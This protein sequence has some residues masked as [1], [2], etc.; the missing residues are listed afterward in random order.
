MVLQAQAPQAISYQAVARD[1]TG[2]P[3]TDQAIGLR[4]E[5]HQASPGGTVTSRLAPSGMASGA[6]PSHTCASMPSACKTA[7]FAADRTVPATGPGQ[8]RAS[9]SAL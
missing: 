1:N 8:I 4:F 9:C 5:V 6:V 3:L 7:A 2:D